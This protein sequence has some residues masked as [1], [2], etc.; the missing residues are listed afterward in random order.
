LQENGVLKSVLFIVIY[1]TQACY[2]YCKQS[3]TNTEHTIAIIRFF[4][5]YKPFL[6]LLKA[7]SVICLDMLCQ[8]KR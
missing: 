8:V 1:C 4:Y 7:T 3:F 2:V 6:S 5:A